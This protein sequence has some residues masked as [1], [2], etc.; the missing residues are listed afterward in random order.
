VI[1]VARNLEHHGRMKH[2]DLRFFWLRDMVS[3]GVI[4]VRYIPTA[5]MA[6]DLLT[7]ALARVKVAAG[8]PQ[9]GLTAPQARPAA[10][11]RSEC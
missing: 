5:D 9:L 3:S 1:P 10:Q 8:L 4:A 2:L 11:V 7:K 6:A